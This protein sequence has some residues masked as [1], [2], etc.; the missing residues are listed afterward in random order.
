ML[1]QGLIPETLKIISFVGIHDFKYKARD[2][3]VGP[4]Q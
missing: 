1:K 4:D 2:W 3:E